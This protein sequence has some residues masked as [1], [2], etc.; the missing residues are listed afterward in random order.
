MSQSVKRKA[1][2]ILFESRISVVGSNSPSL[3]SRVSATLVSLSSGAV[4]AR[5]WRYYPGTWKSDI[6][7]AGWR[8]L[9]RT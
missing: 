6:W 8:P 3:Q 4:V 7:N 1:R 5:S 9:R 2:C